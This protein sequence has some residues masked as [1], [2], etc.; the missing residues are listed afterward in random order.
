MFVKSA[1]SA[2]P[3]RGSY[4]AGAAGPSADQCVFAV[5]L[6]A[7]LLPSVL[8]H[9][10]S[11]DVGL[12]L[13]IAGLLLAIT[14]PVGIEYRNRAYRPRRIVILD[15]RTHQ[16]GHAVARDA[17]RTLSG[18]GRDWLVEYKSPTDTEGESLAWQVREIQTAVIDDLDGIIII[19]AHDDR[20]L[21]FA[22][23]T[24]IK[25]GMF[26]VVVDTKPPNTVFRNIGIEPPRF[27]SSR[28]DRTGQL[29]GDLLVEWL[30]AKADRQV[31]LWTG[32]SGSFAGEERSR[33]ILFKV[34][35][36][37][38]VERA[39]FIQMDSWA[40]SSERC[41][42]TLKQVEMAAGDVAVY[43]AD[44]ENAMALHW[45]TVA[46]RPALRRRMFV[47]GCNATPDDWGEVPAV[48]MRAADATVDILSEEQG[49]QAALLF[50]KERSGKLPNSER[51]VFIQPELVRNTTKGD[52][53][54]SLFVAERNDHHDADMVTTITQDQ[55]GKI[56]TEVRHEGMS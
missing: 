21:W 46:E 52:W 11:V 27:V 8:M 43:C 32:P 47:V 19:P 45:L 56:I 23:A 31:V 41:Q 42:R 37:N 44:D 34:A 15:Y 10:L 20:D 9:M 36:A 12:N 22:L 4:V 28:Y 35:D 29:I 26:A 14:L 16:F 7:A 48:A 49:V 30:F 6:V 50:I 54:Q 3:K 33:N 39:T 51:S 25:S 38:L 5:A 55:N 2:V 18:D 1:Y 24:A 17:M 40:P 13:T 53:L